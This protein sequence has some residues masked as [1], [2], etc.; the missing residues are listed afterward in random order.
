MPWDTFATLLHPTF[1]SFQL[2]LFRCI[3]IHRSQM[4]KSYQQ[5][6]S[7]SNLP[8]KTLRPPKEFFTFP[9][10]DSLHIANKSCCTQ[11]ILL[12]QLPIS[13][14]VTICINLVAITRRLLDTLATRVCLHPFQRLITSL[15]LRR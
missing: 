3:F 12:S 15:P 13:K 7:Q 14:L 4:D 8:T 10:F 5:P 6:S 1:P 9:E 11:E 2:P